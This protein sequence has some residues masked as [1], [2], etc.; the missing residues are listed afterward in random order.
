[1]EDLYNSHQQTPPTIK[2]IHQTNLLQ[3]KSFNFTLSWP[4]L[5]P[6]PQYIFAVHVSLQYMCLCSRGVFAYRV[7]DKRLR[8]VAAQRVRVCVCM[9]RFG[10]VIIA[11][12]RSSACGVYAM[13]CVRGDVCSM[14]TAPKV[15]GST[16]A[17]AAALRNKLKQMEEDDD[18]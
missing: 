11:L 5:P 14:M 10:R 18:W 15:K 12:I 2:S 17:M 6:P 13:C 4:Q 8:H 16:A 7:L 9:C 3:T 1:M